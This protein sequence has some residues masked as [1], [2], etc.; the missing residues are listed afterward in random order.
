MQNYPTFDDFRG[1]FTPIK[2]EIKPDS[3][4]NWDQ[5]NISINSKKGT[6]RGMHYQSRNPQQKYIKVVSGSIIDYL[7]NLETKE[8]MSFELNKSKE[9]FVSK[10]YAHGFLTLEDNTTVAYLTEGQ[11]DPEFEHSIPYKD[12]P[13]I[14]ESVLSHFSE[15]EIII[16]GKDSFGKKLT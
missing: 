12:I 11:Y 6:F 4:K 16:N 10:E 7:Y 15:N 2:L 3:V 1:S 13:I 14:K 8:V 9:I 5:V